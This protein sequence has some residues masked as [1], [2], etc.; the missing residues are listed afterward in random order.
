MG[1]LEVLGLRKKGYSL[2]DLWD[3]MKVF[4]EEV[5]LVKQKKQGWRE[6]QLRERMFK[7]IRNLRD[8]GVIVELLS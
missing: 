4:E 3:V 8:E 7:L 5:K 1:I 2:Q 6:E